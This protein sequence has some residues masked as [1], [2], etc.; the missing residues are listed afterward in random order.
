MSEGAGWQPA[1]QSNSSGGRSL[2]TNGTPSA[3]LLQSSRTKMKKWGSREGMD[4]PSLIQGEKWWS[5]VL[6]S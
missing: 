2:G 4:L 6:N 1:L 5:R 3:P